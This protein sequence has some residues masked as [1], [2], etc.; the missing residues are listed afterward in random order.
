MDWDEDQ[1]VKKAL[2]AWARLW[3]QFASIALG[4]LGTVFSDVS[5]VPVIKHALAQNQVSFSAFEASSRV[6][7]RLPGF[8]YN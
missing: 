8:W 5:I 3:V 7:C 6:G 1:A 4:H 2:Q